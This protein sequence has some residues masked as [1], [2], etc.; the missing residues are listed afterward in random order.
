MVL[1]SRSP[2][3]L[4]PAKGSTSVWAALLG[5]RL[6]VVSRGPP[7]GLPPHSPLSSSGSSCDCPSATSAANGHEEGQGSEEGASGGDLGPEQPARFWGIAL[8]RCGRPPAP[9]MGGISKMGP[10]TAQLRERG[11]LVIFSPFFSTARPLCAGPCGA[12]GE[13]GSQTCGLPGQEGVSAYG[14]IV[15]GQGKPQPTTQEAHTH[16][17]SALHVLTCCSGHRSRK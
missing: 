1:G 15:N 4:V 8:L 11:Q 5:S 12:T 3:A 16:P 17:P 13:S 10:D 9:G 14:A 2:P 6:P 7:P